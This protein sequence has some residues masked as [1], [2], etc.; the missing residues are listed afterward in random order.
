MPAPR[1]S[2]NTAR[3]PSPTRSCAP[4]TASVRQQPTETPSTSL[5]T[6]GC[7]RGEGITGRQNE[8]GIPDPPWA[9]G[10]AGGTRARPASSLP[11][12]KRKSE[13]ERGPRTGGPPDIRRR[14]ELHR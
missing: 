1:L 3:T 10:L 13:F 12:E 7:L 14:G 4:T 9:V 6:G 5:K 2:G 8:G 11:D